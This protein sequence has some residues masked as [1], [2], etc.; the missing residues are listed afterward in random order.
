M[1]HKA[2]SHDRDGSRA[3]HRAVPFPRSWFLTV[4]LCLYT[5]CL[6]RGVKSA[7]FSGAVTRR[8][9]W[10]F[11]VPVEISGWRD[12]VGYVWTRGLARALLNCCFLFSHPAGLPR[13]FAFHYAAGRKVEHSW[14]KKKSC[15]FCFFYLFTVDQYSPYCSAV[16]PARWPDGCMWHSGGKHMERIGAVCGNTTCSFLSVN[17]W[18]AA[19]DESELD[20]VNHFL[21][22]E[23][24]CKGDRGWMCCSASCFCCSLFSVIQ[25]QNTNEEPTPNAFL[26]VVQAIRANKWFFKVIDSQKLMQVWDLKEQKVFIMFLKQMSNI[27]SFS[28]PYKPNGHGMP[29]SCQIWY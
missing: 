12:Q 5:R 13:A 4:E 2:V 8:A 16:P 14:W 7:T 15:C 19:S 3:H 11:L 28:C 6:T 25:L 1:H 27:N 23:N 9:R 21:F 26:S 10:I 29:A 22:I 17:W 24:S 18:R 20:V